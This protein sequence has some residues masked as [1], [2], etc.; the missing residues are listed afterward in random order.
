M[1][2]EG[3]TQAAEPVEEKKPE[4]ASPQQ[5]GLNISAS[6]ME[7]EGTHKGGL[8]NESWGAS[9]TRGSFGWALDVRRRIW[10]THD[11]PNGFYLFDIW[12][13]DFRCSSHF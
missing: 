2:V 9:G 6:H 10:Q 8:T 12:V 7:I 11:T 1:E 13:S 4:A 3:P 5:G